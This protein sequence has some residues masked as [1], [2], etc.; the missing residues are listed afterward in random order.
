MTV[1]CPNMPACS[2]KKIC[3]L[4]IIIWAFHYPAMNISFIIIIAFLWIKRA[5]SCCIPW[6]LDYNWGYF[7]IYFNWQF[8][9]FNWHF[10]TVE[11]KILWW[12]RIITNHEEILKQKKQSPIVEA[13]RRNVRYVSYIPVVSGN[14]QIIFLKKKKSTNLYNIPFNNWKLYTESC[15]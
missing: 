5:K 9:F 10:L 11:G 3:W 15:L 2:G 1:S 14:T 13:E 8:F 4:E 7:K 12:A 6:I